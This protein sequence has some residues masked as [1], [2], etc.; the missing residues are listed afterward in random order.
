MVVWRGM[1]NDNQMAYEGEITYYL[2]RKIAGT[3]P[4]KPKPP[5]KRGRK[6]VSKA[7]GRVKCKPGMKRCPH[8]IRRGKPAFHH[9]DDMRKDGKLCKHCHARYVSDPPPAKRDTL[10]RL[11]MERMMLE[12]EYTK[13][14]CPKCEAIKTTWNLNTTG[15]CDD[16]SGPELNMKRCSKCIHW[17]QMD[18]FNKGQNYCRLCSNI[19]KSIRYAENK[20]GSEQNED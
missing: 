18:Q 5:A 11:F 8:C 9:P 6:P 10:E 13:R 17:K 4:A 14:Y 19:N 2:K 16:C 1:Q 12:H 3:L 15:Q 7:T 20:K